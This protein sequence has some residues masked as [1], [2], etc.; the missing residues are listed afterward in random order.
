VDDTRHYPAM[1]MR[2]AIGVLI[3]GGVVAGANDRRGNTWPHAV[4]GDREVEGK[5]MFGAEQ[6]WISPDGEPVLFVHVLRADGK[7]VLRA[8][9]RDGDKDVAQDVLVHDFGKDEMLVI[10]R[11]DG[12]LGFQLHS[13]ATH[14]NRYLG[15]RA[16]WKNR[17]VV[18]TK[19]QAFNG[20]QPTPAWLFD[21]EVNPGPV[22][23]WRAMRAGALDANNMNGFSH[24]FDDEPVT[25][26]VD[27]TKT[28]A[29]GRQLLAGLIAA[30]AID[31]LPQLGNHVACD[32]SGCC[33]GD[34]AALAAW[35][36]VTSLCF[37][38]I[39]AS[40][41]GGGSA[42]EMHEARVRSID[43]AGPAAR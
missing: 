9:R 41:P 32:A 1:R 37:A 35:P 15:V 27:G 10:A 17:K 6:R 40:Y 26:T 12:E 7:G 43:V 4:L 20:Y 42:I 25:M 22:A 34:A 23:A 5:T 29:P 18:I 30:P 16:V 28:T 31:A 8:V 13:Y 33:H 14:P 19:Q 38:M 39:T 2:L 36:H 11:D 21:P 24:W 3:A